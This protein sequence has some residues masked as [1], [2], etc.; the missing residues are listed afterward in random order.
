VQLSDDHD[1]AAGMWFLEARFGLVDDPCPPMFPNLDTAQ[2]WIEQR[3]AHA[4]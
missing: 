3:L 4:A 1:D 2:T